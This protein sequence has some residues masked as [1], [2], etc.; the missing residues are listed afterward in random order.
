MNLSQLL[1][2]I[3][4]ARQFGSSDP[5]IAGLSFDSR[6]V[7]PG[8]A[9][10]AVPGEVVDG[11]KYCEAAVSAGA[12]AIIAESQPDT[13][14]EKSVV[15]YAVPDARIAMAEVASLFYG[16]PSYDMK[17]VGITGT[18]GKTTTA[19][20]IHH[21]INSSAGRCGLIGTIHYN[22]GLEQVPAERTTPEAIELQKLLDEAAP[23]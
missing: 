21:L 6:E 2:P 5:D 1:A 10:F 19:F 23:T 13:D 15:W 11:R 17:V 4:D 8:H 3:P 12:I 22:T 7:E 20:L 18:N 9:F 16:Q 14:I